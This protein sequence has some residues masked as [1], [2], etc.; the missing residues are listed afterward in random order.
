MDEVDLLESKIVA[1]RR[2]ARQNTFY[3]LANGQ[4]WMQTEPREVTIDEGDHVT[5][6]RGMLGGYML[7]NR[8]GASTRVG[9]IR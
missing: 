2:Q 9:R 8:D 1:V 4:V 6:R 7:R 5:I 3:R